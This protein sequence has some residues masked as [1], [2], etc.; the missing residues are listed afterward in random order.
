MSYQQASTCAEEAVDRCTT[1]LQGAEYWKSED[2]LDCWLINDIEIRQT[3][4]GLVTVERRHG[5]ENFVLKTS[6]SNG[7]VRL[8]SSFLYLT[9]SLG[10]E[11]HIFVRSNDRRLH[12][13]G[14][15]FVVRNAGHAA[16]FDERG[17]LRIW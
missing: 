15:T 3:S 9:A 7:K 6:P 2:N 14:N 16:G 4:D 1:L 12:Y 13:N 17:L 10:M 8:Q 11:S 5:S